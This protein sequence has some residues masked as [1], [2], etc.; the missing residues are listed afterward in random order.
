[1]HVVISPLPS[2]ARLA[3]RKKP[4]TFSFGSKTLKYI[5][6]LKFGSG[7][8]SC[9]YSSSGPRRTPMRGDASGRPSPRPHERG[10][11]VGG[12]LRHLRVR[13][14]T[15]RVRH[16]VRGAAADLER[17]PARHRVAVDRDAPAAEPA[18]AHH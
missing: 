15:A 4:P 3:K 18:E 6:S 16:H 1:M 13:I 12:Q 5:D 11:Q 9:R 2:L 7:P 10:A 17:L 14:E 8:S